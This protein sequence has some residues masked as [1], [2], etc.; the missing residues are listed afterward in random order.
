MLQRF[1]HRILSYFVKS[2]PVNFLSVFF[3]VQRVGQMPG[4]RFPLTVRVRCQ[5]YFFRFFNLLA[6]IRQDI[7]LAADGNIF[8]F[9]IMLNIN[10]QLALRQIPYVTVACG[11]LIIRAK[12]LLDCFYLCR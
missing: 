8:R 7:P 6:K 1:L 4:N 12:E 11:H 2:D 5:I 10:S 9:I 3:Q